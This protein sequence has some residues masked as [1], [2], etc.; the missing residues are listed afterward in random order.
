MNFFKLAAVQRE[1]PDEAGLERIAR[2]IAAL[3]QQVDADVLLVWARRADDYWFVSASLSAL[4]AWL[5]TF[6]LSQSA[7]WL[8]ATQLLAIQLPLWSLL[9]MLLRWPPLLRR[10]TPAALRQARVARFARQQFV[11][12]GLHHVPE[13]K[14]VLIMF[15]ELEHRIEMLCDRGL[16]NETDIDWQLAVQDLSSAIRAKGVEQGILGLI[17]HLAERLPPRDDACQRP[18]RIENALLVLD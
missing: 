13:E 10:C 7:L 5:G 2:A 14:G 11:D 17:D 4:L 8:S 15:C 9:L 3:E 18:N 12:Q 6:L 16:H 1:M